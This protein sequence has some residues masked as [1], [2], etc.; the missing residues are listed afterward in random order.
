MSDTDTPKK[1]TLEE[2][3]EQLNEE[4]IDFCNERSI[5]GAE[6]YGQYAFLENDMFQYMLEE[7][8]DLANYARFTYIKLRLMEETARESGIDMSPSPLGE[9]RTDHEVPL[10]ASAFTPQHKVSGFLPGEES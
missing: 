5:E 1:L 2:R 9:I 3:I 6:T 10:G 8:A 4:F 7:I